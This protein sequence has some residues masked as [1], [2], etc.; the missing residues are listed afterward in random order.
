VSQRPTYPPPPRPLEEETGGRAGLLGGVLGL[1]G[2]ALSWARAN[3]V[4]AIAAIV[5]LALIV[6]AA[7]FLL[8]GRGTGG[9]VGEAT[10][11]PLA[12]ESQ[13]EVAIELPTPDFA[14]TQ[15]ALSEAAPIPE[16]TEEP[17]QEPTEEPTPEP[18]EEPASEPSACPSTHT[19][20]PGENLF[21]IGLRYDI[22]YQQLAAANGIANPSRIQ[23]GQ[24]LSI[25]SCGSAGGEQVHIVQPGENLF[26]V[27]LRYGITWEQLAAHNNLSDP[28][29]IHPGDALRI[30]D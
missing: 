5:V 21:R 28:R 24:V 26:R 30:P 29:L 13:P 8:R 20:Q 7:V 2:S 17:T 9:E 11:V 6:G 22:P 23:A 25:P 10:P 3:I 12:V 15:L 14:A 18:T 19:V 27:A 16:P 4:I 1:I